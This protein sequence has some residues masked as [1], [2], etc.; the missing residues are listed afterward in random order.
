MLDD[1][2]KANLALWNEWTLIHKESEFYDLAGFKA[3]RESL[4]PIELEELGPQ[5][6]PG[7]TLLHLQCHFGMDTL[8]WAR[9]GAIATG[10]DFSSEAISLARGLADELELPATFVQ[11]DVYELPD[12]LAD[13]FDVVY[14]SWGVLTWLRDLTRWAQVVAHF[15][16]PGGTF[17]IVEF[18]PFAMMLDDR[19][20]NLRF[21]FGYFPDEQPIELE[22]ESSY[23]D[24]TAEVKQPVSYEWRHSLS[25]IVD[26]LIGAGLR[27]EHLHEFPYTWGLTFACLEKCPDGWQRVRGRHDDVPLSFSIKA[28]KAK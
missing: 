2:T 8:A 5:I 23:A 16:R 22:T 9:H 21:S 17:Y 20:V 28:V 1:F 18:H 27:L 12:R 3:G 24:E 6:G 25:E 7:T 26:A 4:M 14:T 11:S 10:V 13:T 15:L 19:D